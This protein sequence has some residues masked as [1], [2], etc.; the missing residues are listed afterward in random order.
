MSTKRTK[1]KAPAGY[2]L[3]RHPGTH[4]NSRG[5]GVKSKGAVTEARPLMPDGAIDVLWFDEDE[6]FVE[7][8]NDGMGPN[9]SDEA[10][11]A[12]RAGKP[13]KGWN[14]NVTVKP[15]KDGWMPPSY[16]LTK[17]DDS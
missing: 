11:D 14:P 12:A 8:E 2:V 1:W 13:L 9:A 7:T 4:V 10:K 3:T 17:K 6:P 15:I 16:T 5:F